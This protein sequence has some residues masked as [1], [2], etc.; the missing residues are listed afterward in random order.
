MLLPALMV[1]IG[2]I[3]LLSTYFLFSAFIIITH[4]HMYVTRRSGHE[5]VHNIKAMHFLRL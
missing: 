4:I 1:D 3:R 5:R 2:F